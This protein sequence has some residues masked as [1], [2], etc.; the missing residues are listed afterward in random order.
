VCSVTNL[1]LTD[2]YLISLFAADYLKGM[3]RLKH[4][5][6]SCE[7]VFFTFFEFW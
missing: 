1:E 6:S 5:G 2:V 7:C 4:I 3:Y